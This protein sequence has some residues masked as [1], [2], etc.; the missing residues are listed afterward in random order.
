MNLSGRVTRYLET[1]LVLRE[2]ISVSGFATI[3]S[4]ETDVLCDKVSYFF[5]T[6]RPYFSS[7]KLYRIT[8]LLL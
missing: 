4:T 2:K 3:R 5:Q 6:F 1:G 7:Y 8:K